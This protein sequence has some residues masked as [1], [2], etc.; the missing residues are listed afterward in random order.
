MPNSK[1]IKPSTVLKNVFQKYLSSC[2]WRFFLWDFLGFPGVLACFKG[3]TIW[4]FCDVVVPLCFFR[5][6]FCFASYSIDKFMRVYPAIVKYIFWLAPLFTAWCDP[7]AEMHHK[8]DQSLLYIGTKCPPIEQY[9]PRFFAIIYLVFSM[10][11]FYKSILWSRCFPHIF[12]NWKEYVLVHLFMF[13][14]YR[15]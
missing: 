3:F 4:F 7:G 11:D 5:V 12:L 1:L 8:P 13:F 9:W 14:F 2:P 10:P 6:F 15:F